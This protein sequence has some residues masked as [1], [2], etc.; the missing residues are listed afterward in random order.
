MRS[1]VFC[2]PLRARFGA[3]AGL[4]SLSP[5]LGAVVLQ[6]LQSCD[7]IRIDMTWLDLAWLHLSLSFQYDCL[8][9]DLQ[10][11]LHPYRLDITGRFSYIAVQGFCW[12]SD[13]TREL[14]ALFLPCECIGAWPFS[15]A[16]LPVT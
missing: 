7:S 15:D 11:D 4:Q 5:F 14:A 6:Q 13:P 3:P 1:G 12:A 8:L 2:H 10:H 9:L 16:A